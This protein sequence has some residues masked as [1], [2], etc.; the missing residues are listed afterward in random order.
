MS[1]DRNGVQTESKR[2]RMEGS[3]P[4]CSMW[5]CGDQKNTSVRHCMKA[6]FSVKKILL[7]WELRGWRETTSKPSTIHFQGECGL[8]V[9]SKL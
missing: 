5:K 3:G 9:S 4:M 2:D 1:Q 8:F 7:P 6:G